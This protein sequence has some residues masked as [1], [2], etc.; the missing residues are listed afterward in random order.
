MAQIYQLFDDDDDDGDDETQSSTP[1]DDSLSPPR[2]TLS[3]EQDYS[4][5][6]FNNS[7]VIHHLDDGDSFPDDLDDD[8]L[9]SCLEEKEDLLN[10][11]FLDRFPDDKTSVSYPNRDICSDQQSCILA[12]K[13]SRP[14]NPIVESKEPPSEDESKSQQQVQYLVT[15]LREKLEGILLLARQSSFLFVCLCHQLNQLST[16]LVSRR[17]RRVRDLRRDQGAFPSLLTNIGCSMLVAK[18]PLDASWE[19][20]RN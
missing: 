3:L 12:T 1:I 4:C 16:K 6:L 17:M 5:D 2:E 15:K 9:F 8:L 14:L 20:V 11:W 18:S 10:D 13:K 19:H 7:A